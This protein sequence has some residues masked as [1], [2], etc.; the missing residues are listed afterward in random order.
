M[1]T[2]PLNLIAYRKT[3]V[4]TE[5]TIPKG[6]LDRHTTKEGIWAK[7]WVLSGQLCYRILMEPPEENRLT[8]D[9]PGIIEP[10]VPHQIASIGPVEFYVEFYHEA[11]S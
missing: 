1:K 7:I 3:S 6:L 10:Q 9:L 4:F 5:D 2:L 8:P 11:D